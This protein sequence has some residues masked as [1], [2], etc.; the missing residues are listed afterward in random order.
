MKILIITYSYTPD[1]TPRA[2]RWSA[3]A[4]Q[5]VRLGHEVHVLCSARANGETVMQGDGVH[6]HRVPDWLLNASRRVTPTIASTA[7]PPQSTRLHRLKATLR[8]VAR[9]FWRTTYWPDYACGWIIPATKAADGLCANHT[10]DWIVS[11]SHPFTG[12]V[13]GKRIQ[14]HSGDAKWLVDISDP[15]HLMPEPAP[16]NRWLYAT[17]NR[18]VE[19]RILEEADVI[20]VTTESTRQM[21]LTN[22]AVPPAKIH[23]AP[24]LLSLPSLSLGESRSAR[25]VLRLVFVGTL[26][27]KLRNPAYMLTCFEALISTI[28]DRKLELHIYGAVNDCA[29][30]LAGCS[31]LVKDSLFVHGLVDR[32]TVHA[33]MQDADILINIG[34][35]SATQLASKVIE[36]MAVGR[37]I[38]N[39]ISIDEDTSVQALRLY[40]ATLTLKRIAHAP[41]QEEL[42]RLRAFALNPPRVSSDHTE[43]V[44]AQFSVEHV[45][46][47]YMAMLLGKPP[48]DTTVQLHPLE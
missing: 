14:K 31:A 47:L 41:S 29:E 9:A 37:P 36:Y 38:L 30:T 18:R 46:S 26:Y 3:L 39:L 48:S 34:N 13:V 43:M 20:C 25:H 4:T 8:K 33:A 15:F 10:F 44:R 42:A 16:N 12:H 11:V 32:S 19:G 1:L 40:P 21:Y 6:V 2:F 17:L 28:H 23:V 35:D 27:R 45:T 5:M 22:F 7:Q 24:P